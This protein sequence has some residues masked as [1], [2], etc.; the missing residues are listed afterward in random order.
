MCIHTSPAKRSCCMDTSR[1]SAPWLMNYKIGNPIESVG[2]LGQHH[3]KC[4][5][6]SIN[7][8]STIRSW[9]R[10][11]SESGSWLKMVLKFSIRDINHNASGPKCLAQAQPSHRSKSKSCLEP[12]NNH[13]SSSSTNPSSW[14]GTSSSRPNKLDRNKFQSRH[15]DC[16]TSVRN[17]N[18]IMVW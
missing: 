2:R 14:T 8:N 16:K 9:F 5:P 13:T 18:P 7:A 12:K 4:I 1:H 10:T 11:M 3:L 17:S 15:V 6:L